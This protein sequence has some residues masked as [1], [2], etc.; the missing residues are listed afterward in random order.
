[1]VDVY[2]YIKFRF[3]SIFSIMGYYKEYMSLC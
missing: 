3:F 1:M 2:I